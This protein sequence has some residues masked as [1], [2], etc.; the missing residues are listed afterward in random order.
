[1]MNKKEKPK[2]DEYIV[3][4]CLRQR[5]KISKCNLMK[6][7]ESKMRAFIVNGLKPNETRGKDP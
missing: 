1:M 6:A 2:S 4:L 5:L 3:S 7:H